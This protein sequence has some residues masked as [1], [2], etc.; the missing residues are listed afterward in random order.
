MAF[1][2]SLDSTTR[3]DLSF[4]P[5]AF[6]ICQNWQIGKKIEERRK[7]ERKEG[8][9]PSTFLAGGIKEK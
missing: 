4:V 5:F 9:V 1:N 6:K 7:E 2:L 8:K 3:I